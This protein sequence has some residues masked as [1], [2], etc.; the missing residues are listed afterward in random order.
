MVYGVPNMLAQKPE[1]VSALSTILNFTKTWSF[2]MRLFLACVWL[3]LLQET[4]LVEFDINELKKKWNVEFYIAGSS[5]NSRGVA[6][7]LNN[8]FEYQVIKLHLDPDGRFLILSLSIANLYTVTI[9]NVYGP[10]KD[11]PEWYMRLFEKVNSFDNT[12]YLIYAGDWN[13]SLTEMDF[14]NYNSHRNL[15]AISHVQSEMETM[16]L[17][18]IWRLQNPE[19]KRFTWGTKKPFK[20]GRLDFFLISEELLSLCPKSK[21]LG[22]YRSDHNIIS[23]S[24]NIT[25]SPR[26][27]GSWK[28]NNKLLKSSE[29]TKMVKEEIKLI[30]QTYALPVY[31]LDYVSKMPD[32]D[33]ILT[34]DDDLFLDTMLCQ[35]RGVIIAFSKKV[36]KEKRALEKNL[37]KKLSR[38]KLI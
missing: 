19:V 15:K 29:F 11:D 21:I 10:N 5:S 26:G 20:R 17:I 33:V 13:M 22:S 25:N 16:N 9:T 30:K 36:A 3:I 37:E 2:Q 38:W 32:K 1:R 27:R 7:I 14:Y 28:F 4:H 6:L 12:D 24:I 35:L 31:N 18:D 34:I 23:L 8:S